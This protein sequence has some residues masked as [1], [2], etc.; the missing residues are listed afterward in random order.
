MTQTSQNQPLPYETAEEARLSTAV[1]HY[2]LNPA[3]GTLHA[4]EQQLLPHEASPR[5]AAVMVQAA[6]VVL[7][8][9]I[10]QLAAI[11]AQQGSAMVCR[12]GC[13]GCCHHLVP[14]QPFEAALIGLYVAARPELRAFFD[15][16]YP[17]WDERTR[18]LR[19]SYLAWGE[20]YY[21]DGVDDGTH[22]LED[23]YTPCLFLDDGRCRIYPVRPYP[24]RSCVSVAEEC[25]T[26]TAPGG[27]SGMHSMDCGAYTTHKHSRKVLTDLLW[28]T[29][30][31]GPEA[32]GNRPMPD[33]VRCFLEKGFPAALRYA[34]AEG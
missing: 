9:E 12:A 14:C 1:T 19:E 10:G 8:A 5:T 25:R 28:R 22:R 11:I 31:P 7:D 33:L 32:A 23:Y 3:E 27:R 16:A 17:K 18:G 24:C 15:A 13:T 20:R 34:S 6:N 26:P 30:G 2:F 4:L 29:C 21:R